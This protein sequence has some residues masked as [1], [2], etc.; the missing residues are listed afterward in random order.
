MKLEADG[1]RGSVEQQTENVTST[2]R[3]PLYDYWHCP[4]SERTAADEETISKFNHFGSVN[5][6]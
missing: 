2:A 1:A 5:N 6:L 4:R 3:L